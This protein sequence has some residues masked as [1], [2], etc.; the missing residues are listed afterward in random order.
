ML[1]AA[2]MRLGDAEGSRKQEELAREQSDT[3]WPDP[4]TRGIAKLKTGLATM[5]SKASIAHG[6][7]RYNDAI[8]I[9]TNAVTQYPESVFARI[10]LG[11]TR[12]RLG[13]IA[14][15]Q[16]DMATALNHYQVAERQLKT[17]LSLDSNSAEAHFRLGVV[18]LYMSSLN[19]HQEKLPEAEQ[20]F[21]RAISIKSDF[22]MAYFDLARCLDKQKRF[23][24]AIVEMR[25]TLDCNPNN[26]Q[27]QRSLGG[28]LMKA[29]H[30]QE[31][32]IELEKTIQLAPNDK[33]AREWLKMIRQDLGE[34]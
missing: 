28:L 4:H 25:R 17:A 21:R 2:L 26:I 23:P 13:R 19:G 6:Q 15:Q 10:G 30:L 32:M 18:S 8:A 12:I 1:A 7:K 9:L 24:E 5:L 16:G 14:Y 27:A 29:G 33:K 3:P 34:S 31:A 20:W 22:E 11:R